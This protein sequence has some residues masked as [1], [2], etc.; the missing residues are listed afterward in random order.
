MLRFFGFVKSREYQYT[1]VIASLDNIKTIEAFKMK[2]KEN[3]TMFLEA[4]KDS[5]YNDRFNVKNLG[6]MAFYTVNSNLVYYL[7]EES[8]YAVAEISEGKLFLHQ[9]VADHKVYL[10]KEGALC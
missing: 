6:L 5:V 2:N 7:E 8:C 4:V 3:W 10:D 9:I 1:K